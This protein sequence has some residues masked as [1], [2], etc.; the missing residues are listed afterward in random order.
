VLHLLIVKAA[1]VLTK[2]ADVPRSIRHWASRL[3][4]FPGN[5]R[6]STASSWGL[7]NR[8]VAVSPLSLREKRIGN[9]LYR[10]TRVPF[11]VRRAVVIGIRRQETSPTWGNG[12][13][14]QCC[15]RTTWNHGQYVA[16][17]SWY[18]RLPS[19]SAERQVL[20]GN[21]VAGNRREQSPI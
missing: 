19:G 9:W 7:L 3:S 5:T 21:S 6:G 14:E 13:I 1:I 8:Q 11:A 18:N 10:L 12:R 20:P 17:H 4:S 2:Q 15:K 16:S